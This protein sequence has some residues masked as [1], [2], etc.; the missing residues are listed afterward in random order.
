M[1]PIKSCPAVCNIFYII[2]C[3]K[4]FPIVFIDSGH[5]PFVRLTRIIVVML[6]PIKHMHSFKTPAEAALKKVW[7]L[8]LSLVHSDSSRKI[9]LQL[10]KMKVHFPPTW[11]S[12]Y[13]NALFLLFTN[14]WW[15]AIL[16]HL[17]LQRPPMVTSEMLTFWYI[18]RYYKVSL[19]SRFAGV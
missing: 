19:V 8:I 13:R 18:I 9:S 6:N 5:C 2:I 1:K 7:R 3:S 17:W 15:G 10:L 11:I 4:T 12:N 14:I 16:Y